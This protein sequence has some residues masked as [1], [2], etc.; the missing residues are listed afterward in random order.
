MLLFGLD[1]SRP[2]AHKIVLALGIGL[3]PLEERDFEDG[4]HKARP[5]VGVRDRDRRR[6]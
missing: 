3:A 2:F 4:E 5:L 1:A 6:S